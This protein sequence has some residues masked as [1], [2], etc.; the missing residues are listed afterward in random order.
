MKN[1]RM[2]TLKNNGI[3][4]GRFFTLVV[5]ETIPAGTRINISIE[6][7]EVIA[8]QIIEDGYVRNTKLHRRFVAAQYMRM[9]NSENGW[10]DYLNR[11]Y[12]Y[13]YQF[14]M[15]VEEVRVLKEIAKRDIDTFRERSKF[16]TYSVVMQVIADYRV[17]MIKYVSGL[18]KKNCKGVPYVNI[19]GYGNVFVHDI[20]E[21]VIAPIDAVINR[22]L[23][24]NNFSDL[25]DAL[26]VFKYRMVKLPY[27]TKK[28]KTWVDAFQKEGAFYTLKNLIMFH[29][30]N[31]ACDG[32]MCDNTESSMEV[33]NDLVR[34]HAGYKM[35]AVLKNTIEA[36]NFNFA[37]SIE[38]HK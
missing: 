28:S 20:D 33:L 8:K 31:L 23:D 29:D 30:V 26:V 14:D 27:Y 16:F 17:D 7:N 6:E 25:Y 18:P 24:C 19:K 9:L 11:R 22:C 37:N 21:R 3:N 10:H 34:T 35:H 2:E 13:M 15:M 36:N 32:I 4:T 5:N 1:N 38:A 12:D